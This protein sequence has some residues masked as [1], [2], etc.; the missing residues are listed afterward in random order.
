ME[1]CFKP[2]KFGKVIDCSLHHFS[3]ASQDGYG[4][5][6]YLRIVDE[7]GYIK[8]SLVMAK[9]RVPPTK[10]VS[11]PRL[12][13]TAAALSIKVSA[14]L[15]RELTIHPTIKEYFWTDSE[16]VL[17]YVNND[18]KR[19]KIFVANRVQL[20]RQNSD[21]NQWMYVDSRSNAADDPHHVEYHHQTRKRSTD[22]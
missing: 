20:I 8:C 11:I 9:S 18:A 15:R 21:V 16:V 10:F 3:D 5:V 4:Q 19:F 12:E 1:R 14:M 6:T 22:G 2:S 7:K 17:G 13:L